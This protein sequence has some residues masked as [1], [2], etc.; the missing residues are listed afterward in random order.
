MADTGP[1]KGEI[2]FMTPFKI[3]DDPPT[4]KPIPDLIYPERTLAERAA[5]RFSLAGKSAIVTGGA[6]GLGLVCARALLEHGVEKLAIFDVDET[7]GAKALE[8]FESTC[9]GEKPTVLFRKVDVANEASVNDAVTDVSASF[10]G[11][12]ILLCFAGITE[13]K[14]A[15]EYNIDSWRHIFD[16]NV[17]GSFLVARAVARDVIARNLPSA[18]IVF[19]ASMSGYIVNQPQPHSAYAVSKASVHHLARSMAGEW[20]GHGIRVNSI[21]P[22]I[23]NTRLSGGPS[24]QA[25]RRLWLEKSP[26]GIGDPEDLT[27]AVVLLCSE[28]GRFITGTD[29]KIDG[30]YTI[31]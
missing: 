15:V 9:K 28:A 12:A 31:F 23:M 29:V 7:M 30:G 27:G 17:H 5:A 14:L 25:L 13:S 2:K 16:V 1:P 10:N 24:Q 20:V 6:Q 21:S 4:P 26:L 8:H 3:A 18:S 11:I 19:T 22:G